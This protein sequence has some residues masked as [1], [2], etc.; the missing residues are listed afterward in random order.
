MPTRPKSPPRCFPRKAEK[1]WRWRTCGCRLPNPVRKSL[2][3]ERRREC[4]RWRLHQIRDLDDLLLNR[5]LHQLRL[6]VDVQLAHQVELMRFHGL[7]AQVQ[8]TGD[9]FD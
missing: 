9:F 1:Q 3:K 2:W 8:V 6:V 5:V 4:W 7:D